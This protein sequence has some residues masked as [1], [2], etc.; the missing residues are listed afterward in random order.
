VT[1]SKLQHERLRAGEPVRL[2]SGLALLAIERTRIVAHGAGAWR[3]CFAR[4]EPYALV[5]RGA[6]DTVRV[7]AVGADPVSL[8]ALSGAVPHWER[9]SSALSSGVERGAAG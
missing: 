3:G 4:L 9:V 8:G 6:D 1:E 5:F 2:S 7:L